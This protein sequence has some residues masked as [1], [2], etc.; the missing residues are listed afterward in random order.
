MLRPPPRLAAPGNPGID[1]ALAVF[2]DAGFDMAVLHHH[3]V[4]EHGHVGHAAVAVPPVEIGAE[5]GILL[6]RRHGAALFADDVGIARQDLLEIAR[7]AEFVGDDAHG[8]A[9]PTLV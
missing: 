1:A 5:H 3:R 7:G 8:N 2:D 9:G 6:R 4:V